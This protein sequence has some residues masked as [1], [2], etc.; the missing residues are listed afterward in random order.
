MRR[1]VPI[2][3]AIAIVLVLPAPAQAAVSFTQN[4]WGINFTNADGTWVVYTGCFGPTYR[5]GTNLTVGPGYIARVIRRAPDNVKI[6]EDETPL[7]DGAGNL[8]SGSGLGGFAFH[9]AR[10]QSPFFFNGNTAW[11]V[12]GRF[13][14]ED[15]GF[16]VQRAQ[17]LRGPVQVGPNRAD[18]DIDVYFQEWCNRDIARV[19]YKYQVL[20]SV[21]KVWVLV[22]ELDDGCVAYNGGV[23]WIKEPK[24]FNSV[25]PADYTRLQVFKADNTLAQNV[26]HG[27]NPDNLWCSWLG[28]NPKVDTRQC[29]NDQR[30]RFRWD[31]GTDVTGPGNCSTTRLCLTAI[32]R[33]Y[34]GGS[35]ITPGGAS[36][37]WEK[38][39]LGI[40]QWAALSAGRPK[41]NTQ[42]GPGDG[43]HP[44]QCAR[45][46]N[47]ELERRWEL[48]GGPG[49]GGFRGLFHG[50]EGGV[51]PYDCEPQ[52]TRFGSSIGFPGESWGMHFE[53]SINDGWA[54]Q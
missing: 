46:L 18:L 6:V 24:F 15:L 14:K 31:F 21:V 37:N 35:D 44:S 42:D 34:A 54:L 30:A 45:P 28:A 48:T 51:G 29:E 10:G 1:L 12:E 17:I 33:A 53:F 16:G 22:T 9:L 43:Y 40:D 25:L 26:V 27:D 39:G 7:R 49:W 20:D 11:P 5:G 3:L 38:S 8:V 32:G 19:R 52:S 2:G 50:W 23:A 13:C 4:Q 36:Y 41:A 47:G